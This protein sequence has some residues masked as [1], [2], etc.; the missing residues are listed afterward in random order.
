M[1]SKYLKEFTIHQNAVTRGDWVILTAAIA[2]M[3]ISV[4]AYIADGP[5]DLAEAGMI[6]AE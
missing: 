1:F 5:G 3:G 2:G 6:V 4:F